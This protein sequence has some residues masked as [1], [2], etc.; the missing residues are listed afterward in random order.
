MLRLVDQRNQARVGGV[1]ALNARLTVSGQY[2]FDLQLQIVD[3]Q[4]V[5]EITEGVGAPRVL[6]VAESGST[7]TNDGALALAYATLPTGA[8][9]GTWYTFHVE[10]TDGLRITAT[11][12]EIIEMGGLESAAA[13]FLQAASQPALLVCASTPRQA[14]A[15]LGSGSRAEGIALQLR[16]YTDS[17]LDAARRMCE[18]DDVTLWDMEERLPRQSFLRRHA[19]YDSHYRCHW[20]LAAVPEAC[21]QLIPSVV[22]ARVL[23]GCERY[24]YYYLNASPTWYGWLVNNTYALNEVNGALH[25]LGAAAAFM[26]SRVDGAK[27]LRRASRS[28]AAAEVYAMTNPRQSRCDCRTA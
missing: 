21:G 18:R 14:A 12:A 15:Y 28:G 27:E 13:G 23:A 16:H 20:E 7:I 9:I 10:D 17:D 24:L 5:I 25:P 1:D 4:S 6:T 19:A 2:R 26:A 22:R 8:P 3:E 11:G